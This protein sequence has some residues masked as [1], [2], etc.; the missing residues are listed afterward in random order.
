MLVENGP[1]KLVVEIVVLVG[2]CATGTL[3]AILDVEEAEVEGDEEE[4]F[5]DTFADM[6]VDRPL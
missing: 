2:T 4:Q 3:A 1:N 6:P 5:I